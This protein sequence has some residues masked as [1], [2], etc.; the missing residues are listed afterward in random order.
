MNTMTRHDDRNQTNLVAKTNS[1]VRLS[2]PDRSATTPTPRP[3][4]DDDDDSQWVTQ[5]MFDHYNG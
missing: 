3:A 1:N 4:V 5:R 2:A